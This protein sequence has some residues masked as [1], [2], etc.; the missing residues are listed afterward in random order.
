MK[1]DEKDEIEFWIKVL[2]K[3]SRKEK[4]WKMKFRN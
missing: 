2:M 4:L 1:K 3:M